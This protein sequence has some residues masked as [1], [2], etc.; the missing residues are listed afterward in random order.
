MYNDNVRIVLVVPDN[1]ETCIQE[2]K[3]EPEMT[4]RFISG[5]VKTP[6]IPPSQNTD[7][8]KV[9]A[10]ITTTSPPTIGCLRTTKHI[11]I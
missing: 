4:I 7:P 6:I 2:I 3:V 8:L 10:Q 9:V 1:T 11:V 5:N